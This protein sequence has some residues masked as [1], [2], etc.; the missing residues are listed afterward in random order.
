MVAWAIA[1]MLRGTYYAMNGHQ[2]N[3]AGAQCV[4]VPN[5]YRAALGVGVWFGDASSWI[6]REDAVTRWTPMSPRV[7]LE[8]G[9]VVVWRNL[10]GGPAGHTALVVDGQLVGAEL[11]LQQNNPLGAPCT[12]ERYDTRAASG[13]LRVRV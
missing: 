4:N 12:L 6:G 9:D 2:L 1:R 8:S 13:F 11:L 10:G 3:E 5:A 7:R